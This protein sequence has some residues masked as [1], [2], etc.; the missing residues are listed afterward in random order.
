MPTS[1]S[2]SGAGG[3][4]PDRYAVAVAPDRR[5]V[6]GVLDA[7]G[8]VEHHAGHHLALDA[9]RRSR[10]RT[11]GCRRG[12]S[13]S[14]RSGRRSSATP[15]VPG[16]SSPSS[17]TN[18]VVGAGRQERAADQPLARPVGLGDDV[19]VAGLGRRDLDAAAR[20]RPATS[21]AGLGRAAARARRA[22]AGRRR[23]VTPPPRT[24]P[25][26]RRAGWGSS[27]TGQRSQ[28]RADGPDARPGH[29]LAPLGGGPLEQQVA[30]HRHEPRVGRRRWRPDAQA[31]P[32]RSAVAI[33][34]V[35]RS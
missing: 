29:V 11:A 32:S 22:R 34:S 23:S 18:R 35:S 25:G 28:R 16:S 31:S 1:R 20:R 30:H 27:P 8:D 2:A 7:G 3:A 9:R 26:G 33:A 6:G 17:P 15:E 14:R 10:R 19:D 4:D 12:S 5:R 13:R 24:A 21:S